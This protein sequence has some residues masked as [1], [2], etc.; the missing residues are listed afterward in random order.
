[1]ERARVI[2]QERQNHSKAEKIDKDHDRDRNERLIL[3]HC[4]LK[5]LRSD[6]HPDLYF[7][8][9]LSVVIPDEGG[10]NEVEGSLVISPLR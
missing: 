6:F 8:V 7:D 1:M 4:A 5:Q 9:I 2:W 10:N 3:K